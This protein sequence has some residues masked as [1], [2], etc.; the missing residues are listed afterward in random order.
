MQKSFAFGLYST[1]T[2]LLSVP[3]GGSGAPLPQLPWASAAA[4]RHHHCLAAAPGALATPP[5]SAAPP[6]AQPHPCQRGCHRRRYFA[7]CVRWGPGWPGQTDHQR[8]RRVVCWTWTIN[9][10][11]IQTMCTATF[12]ARFC[13]GLELSVSIVTSYEIYIYQVQ[14][15]YVKNMLGIYTSNFAVIC[16]VYL[17]YIPYIWHIVI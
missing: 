10:L 11:A 16:Q 12:Q 1:F 15:S 14:L 3:L 2:T 9:T 7:T 4:A 5:P 13:C 6:P 8:L 17:W